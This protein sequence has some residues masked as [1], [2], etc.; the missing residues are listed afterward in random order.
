ML[1]D[2]RS[3]HRR[4]VIKV[5]YVFLAVLIGGGLIFFGIGNGSNF[6]GLL[7]A[8]GGGGG[9]ATGQ[10]QYVKALS[11]A[12]KRAN[13][14]PNSAAA[15]LKV[16][17]AA[18]SLATLP[19]NYLSTSGFTKAG[20]LALNE[21]RTAWNRYLALAAANPNVLFA[22]EI[23]AAF[24]APPGGVG[25]YKT[26]GTAQLVV[27]AAQPNV[28]NY[29]ELAYYAWLSRDDSQGDLAAA[30]A[31][32]IAGKA[33]LSTVDSTLEEMAA[34]AAATTGVSSIPGAIPAVTGASGATGSTGSGKS[35]GATGST[36]G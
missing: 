13:A 7:T 34:A 16:G 30:K 4:R 31:R 25:D 2:L 17:E 24:G 11:T 23:V 15:W 18:Y 19:D 36:G 33:N 6:G 35:A 29:E 5:V 26:A 27:T 9:T 32:S 21:M 28:S 8:A 22:Q 14:S 3:P 1:F 20:H 12:E 10:K